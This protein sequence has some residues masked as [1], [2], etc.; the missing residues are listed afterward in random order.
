VSSRG[1]RWVWLVWLSVPAAVALLAATVALGWGRPATGTQPAFSGLYLLTAVGTVSFVVAGALIASRRPRNPV[2]WLVVATPLVHVFA[3][4]VTEYALRGL[5]VEPGAWSGAV[6]ADWL[7]QWTRSPAYALGPL[8]LLLFPDGR[9]L[10]RWWHNVARAAASLGLLVLL[11]VPAATWSHRGRYVLEGHRTDLLGALHTHVLLP[12]MVATAVLAVVSLF[13][14]YRR[15]DVVTRLQFRWFALGAVVIATSVVFIAL[16]LD[17]RVGTVLEAAGMVA[18]SVGLGVALLR[19]RLYEID[20]ILSRTVSYGLVL[21]VLGTV[22]VAIVLVTG[23]GLSAVAGEAGSDLA[24]AA[25][26]LVVAAL[27]RPVRARVQAAVDRR[28]NRTGY[29]AHRA[30]DRFAQ[31][32]RNEVD[33]DAIGRAVASTAVVAVQPRSVSLW[34]APRED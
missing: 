13:H 15:G 9:P 25:S 4:F 16:D 32:L 22:Y 27:F 19:Y 24:V 5:L 11:L 17:E 26:V 6:I 30:V 31:S 29:E 34:L 12:M 10:N 1:V 3:E 28:F 33:L 18:L 20:R 8:I 7:A 21:A 2:G 14:R 23:T